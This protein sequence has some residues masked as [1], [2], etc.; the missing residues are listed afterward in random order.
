MTGHSDFS[1][2][3]ISNCN[4]ASRANNWIPVG[5]NCALYFVKGGV[6]VCLSGGCLYTLPL[7]SRWQPRNVYSVYT[8]ISD[9]CKPGWQ[10]GTSLDLFLLFLL[11]LRILKWIRNKDK[12]EGSETC[13]LIKL[14][15]TSVTYRAG[16]LC[17]RGHLSSTSRSVSECCEKWTFFL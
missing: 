4:R 13:F 1:W 15:F 16:E 12:K 7:Q 14:F 5:Y 9:G 8:Q 3:V 11:D 2:N 17:T 10:W 6:P